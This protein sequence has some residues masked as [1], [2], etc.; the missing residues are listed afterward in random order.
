MNKFFFSVIAIFFATRLY[1]QAEPATY[2]N[3][4]LEFKIFYNTNHIDSIF[5]RFSPDLKKVL[6]EDKFVPTTT[7]LKKEIGALQQTE[8]VK[9]ENGVAIYKAAF[10]K[11]VVMLNIGLDKNS[12][13]TGLQ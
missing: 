9:M 6:P 1:A 4:A 10:E 3:A 11:A 12:E 2:A 13:Y 5:N 7:Q 8:F